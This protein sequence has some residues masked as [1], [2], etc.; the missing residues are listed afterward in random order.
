VRQYKLT[1]I[2]TIESTPP[3]LDRPGSRKHAFTN[4]FPPND[5]EKW[6]RFIEA[7]FDHAID[8]YGQAEVETWL[9]E[10][11]NEPSF[12]GIYYFGTQEDF[13]KLAEQ[14]YLAADRVEKRRGVNLKMGLTSGGEG[15]I[16]ML[17]NLQRL[18]KL[19]LIDHYSVHIYA[20]VMSSI[21]TFQ[22]VAASMDDY[23]KQFPQLKPYLKGC[24]EWNGTSTGGE[25]QALPWN[26]SFVVKAIRLMLDGGLDYATYFDLSDNP[27]ANNL[28]DSIFVFGGQMGLFTRGDVPVPKPAYN[29]FVFLNEL[30]GGK[31]LKLQSSNDP[32]DGVAVQMPDGTIRIVLTN[33]DED[34]SRQPYSTKVTVTLSEDQ[35]SYR[36]TRLWAAD[37]TH[38]NTYKKWIELNR[39]A[40]T[41]TRAA[42]AIVDAGKP[43]VLVPPTIEVR[44]TGPTCVIDVPS[45]GIRFIEFQPISKNVNP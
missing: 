33:Y 18:G 45:P 17:K 16:E 4:R 32:I 40:I 9:W 10:I 12:T 15:N 2:V 11:W 42:Q 13:L 43:G 22:E 6:G 24:T 26:A 34:I 39:P 31:R 28:P 35:K 14:V 41:D 30:K 23:R 25:S 1:P 8:R 21:R 20:G 19:D 27:E 3:A 29:A 5:F 44:Q 7:I 38:G 37:D 36:C